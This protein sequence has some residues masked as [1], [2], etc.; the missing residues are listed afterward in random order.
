[1]RFILHL[2]EDKKRR[3]ARDHLLRR[4]RHTCWRVF[5]LSEGRRISLEKVLP[6]RRRHTQEFGRIPWLRA[7][8][9]EER[10]IP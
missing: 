7:H 2:W 10:R 4:R 5:P 8:L 1:M 3:R 9:E 6:W